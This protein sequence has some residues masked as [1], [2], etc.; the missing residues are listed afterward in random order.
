MVLA[1]L[2]ASALV[3]CSPETTNA[4]QVVA[5]P[6]PVESAETTTPDDAADP[7]ATYT[8]GCDW[9][10]D[11]AAWSGTMPTRSPVDLGSALIG[12]WQH[13][14]FDDGDGIEP[15]TGDIRYVFPADGEMIYCQHIAGITDRAEQAA[16]ITIVDNR[17]SPPAPH[18]GFDVMLMGDDTMVWINNMD[19]SSYVLVRR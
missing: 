8:A 10:H 16:P 14:H 15:V 17:I 3:A 4:P 12:A 11:P 6:A 13:T 2:T 18:P 1:L 7:P 9:E 5:T 19:G